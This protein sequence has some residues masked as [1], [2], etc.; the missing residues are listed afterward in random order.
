MQRF[1]RRGQ[2]TSCG[3]SQRSYALATR[4]RHG[5]ADLCD[6]AH[7]QVLAGRGPRAHLAA[8]AS[9]TRA[10]AGEVLRLASGA[11]AQATFHA[12]CG[13]HTGDPR[14]LFGGD[15]TGATGSGRA[16]PGRARA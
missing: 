1:R 3:T 11:I 16:G 10:T 15:G 2:N 9:A 6:L 13:G 8:A 12:A 4:G 7:C 14:E 5:D